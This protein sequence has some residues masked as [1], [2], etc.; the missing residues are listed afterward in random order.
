MSANIAQD[1][2]GRPICSISLCGRDAEWEVEMFGKIEYYC[3]KHRP[4]VPE[5]FMVRINQP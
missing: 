3:Q 5:A 2:E 1:S 4:T